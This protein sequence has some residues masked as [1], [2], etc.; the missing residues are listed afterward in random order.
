MADWRMRVPWAA[1]ISSGTPPGP[2]RGPFR[3][4]RRQCQRASCAIDVQTFWPLTSQEPS[5]GE[6]GR[7][8]RVITPEEATGAFPLLHV[9]AAFHG[10]ATRAASRNGAFSSW[11]NP[12]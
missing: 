11:G 5:S 3:A 1:V 8:C 10:G 2:A 4:M 12:Q 6:P 7:R 9:V